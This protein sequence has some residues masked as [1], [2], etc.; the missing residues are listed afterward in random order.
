VKDLAEK[1]GAEDITVSYD[2]NEKKY[3]TGDNVNNILLETIVTVTAVGKPKQ[4]S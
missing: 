1:A 2:V 4:F 3:S